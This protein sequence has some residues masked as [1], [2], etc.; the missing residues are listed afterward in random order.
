[1]CSRIG[2]IV[3][4]QGNTVK[5][6]KLTCRSWSCEDCAK[7]RRR[8]LISEA[9]EGKPERFI[10]LTVNPSWFDS[11]AQRAEKLVEAWRTIRRRF[12][13]LSENNKLEFM[14]VFELT[15]K[16][17]PHLHIMQR[18]SFIPQKWLSEQMQELMG[19]PIVDI[20]IVQSAKKVGEYVSK[21]ISKRNVKIGT[22]KRYWRSMRYLEVSRA[23]LRRRRNAGAVFY[24]LDYHWKSYLKVCDETY[25]VKITSIDNGGFSFEWYEEDEPPWC[26]GE[27]GL[28]ASLRSA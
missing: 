15:A 28:R 11:P 23:E 2:V 14:A 13:A 20:R 17:E 27:L 7:M 25:K 21:Y 3:K 10:T 18:G 4:H 26:V 6:I 5:A 1:M 8:K 19:A 22:L 9:K 12:L 24:I 16:G